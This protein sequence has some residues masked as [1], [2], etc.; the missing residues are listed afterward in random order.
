LLATEEAERGRCRNKDERCGM[1]KEGR[2]GERKVHG[3]DQKKKTHIR[4]R[5][6]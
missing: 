5:G 3:L 4:E 1:R 2:R 6:R